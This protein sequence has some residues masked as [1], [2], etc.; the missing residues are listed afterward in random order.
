MTTFLFSLIFNENVR[1]FIDLI[2]I[3]SERERERERERKRERERER[4]L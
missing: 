1:K 2:F 3:T 4:D